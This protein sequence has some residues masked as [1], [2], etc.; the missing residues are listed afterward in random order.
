[1]SGML[2]WGKR[3][4]C[5]GNGTPLVGGWVAYCQIGTGGT[6]FRNV[7]GDSA[8]TLV[9][10][11]PVPLDASGRP[12]SGGS[13]Q[14]LWGDGSYEEFVYDKDGVLQTSSII[15]APLDDL[16][17]NLTVDGTLTVNGA[18]TLNGPLT[19]NGNETDNGNLSAQNGNFGGLGVSGNASIGG[20]ENVGGALTAGD[21][22]TGNIDAN[23][24]TIQNLD[25]PGT[26]TAGTVNAGQYLNLP[27]TGGGSIM[28]HGGQATWTV[29][30]PLN[31]GF[32]QG[33]YCNISWPAFPNSTI[34]VICIGIQVAQPGNPDEPFILGGAP[35]TSTLT[36]GSCL[37]YAGVIPFTAY[38]DQTY[39]FFWIAF[40]Q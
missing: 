8:E 13:Q 18:T 4:F 1:M 34:G 36:N 10:E 11:N 27:A 12:Y 5:D 14:S 3:Q 38:P 29:Q 21:I 26:L 32:G 37:A 33:L 17:G 22:S 31:P 6:V 25:V 23:S 24:G 9:L 40:G 19:V 15:T 30:A 7:Y 35:I 16:S 2:P 39:P 20:N 28:A